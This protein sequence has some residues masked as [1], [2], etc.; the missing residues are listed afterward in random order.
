MS[1][2]TLFYLNDEYRIVGHFF[3]DIDGDGTVIE[4]AR[5][6]ANGHTIDVWQGKRRVALV[7]TGF[8]PL[9]F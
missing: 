7:K 2:Y 3:L 4:E 8:A 9:V 1:R 5:S 6:R